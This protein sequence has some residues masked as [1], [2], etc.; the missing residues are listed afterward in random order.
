M[1]PPNNIP[2]LVPLVVPLIIK[3]RIYL[4]LR[5]SNF[6]KIYKVIFSFS[7]DFTCKGT[8]ACIIPHELSKSLC[9]IETQCVGL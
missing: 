9:F 8:I 5:N 4:A 1:F 3:G 6:W 2:P 7:K